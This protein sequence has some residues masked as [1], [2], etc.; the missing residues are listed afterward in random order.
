M[1]EETPGTPE[2]I[3]KMIDTHIELGCWRRNGDS[4]YVLCGF[5]QTWC[6]AE[7]EITDPVVGVIAARV[8]PEYGLDCSGGGTLQMHVELRLCVHDHE[9]PAGRKAIFEAVP[10]NHG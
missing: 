8:V 4:Y 1:S 9:C 2:A 3:T 5:C 6:K 7:M 10:H